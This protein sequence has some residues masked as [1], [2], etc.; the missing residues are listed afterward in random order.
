MR[1][2]P[3]KSPQQQSTLM[4]HEARD[5]L[6]GQRTALINALRGHF[7]KLGIVVAQGASN[8]RQLIAYLKDETNSDLPDTARVALQPLAVMLV[9][10]EA[11]IAKRAPSGHSKSAGR[12]TRT[13]AGTSAEVKKDKILKNPSYRLAFGLPQRLLVSAGESALPLATYEVRSGARYIQ[14]PLNSHLSSTVAA[15]RQTE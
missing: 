13:D 14:I 2:V 5:P 8:T 12:Q 4:L 1:F 9:G 3:V 10:I 11:Q 7:A 15:P 6:I